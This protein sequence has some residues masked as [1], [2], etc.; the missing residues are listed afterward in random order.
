MT[1]YYAINIHHF[2]HA[3]KIW[4]NNYIKLSLDND[5]TVWYIDTDIQ[6]WNHFEFLYSI[7]TYFSS[8]MVI[9][10]GIVVFWDTTHIK[11]FVTRL[12]CTLIESIF[13][14]CYSFCIKT[15]PY[16]AKCMQS[17]FTIMRT[18]KFKNTTK[19]QFV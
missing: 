5:Y 4:H 16:Y 12:L 17:I 15:K 1:S 2:L 9:R 13:Y 6:K 10:S 8:L 14:K 7:N 18:L 19:S 11:L 3:Q